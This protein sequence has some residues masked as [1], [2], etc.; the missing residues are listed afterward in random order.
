MY[1]LAQA[2]F[3]TKQYR[4][5]VHVLRAYSIS[6][7]SVRCC[8]LSAK[9]LLESRDYDEALA[10]V[11]RGL[12]LVQEEEGSSARAHGAEGRLSSAACLHLVAARAHTAQDCLSLA[13]RQY[14][15]AVQADVFCV[16]AIDV[17]ARA[18]L[19]ARRRARPLPSSPSGGRAPADPARRLTRPARAA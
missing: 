10:L 1:R 2:Y 19:A 12:D 16:E 7:S 6:Q 14:V 18:L 5:A 17:R 4:R 13:A 3:Y 8:Y 9:C 11:A 15:L